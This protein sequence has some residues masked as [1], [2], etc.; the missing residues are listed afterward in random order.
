MPMGPGRSAPF[1][2]RVGDLGR[3]QGVYE[4]SLVAEGGVFSVRGRPVP[5]T[6]SLDLPGDPAFREM[7]SM[8][9][10]YRAAMRRSFEELEP[11]AWE[12]ED[13]F[14]LHPAERC[15][16]CHPSAVATWR[17]MGHSRSWQALVDA[18]RTDD[19]TCVPCHSRLSTPGS[20]A[21]RNPKARRRRR[22]C[23]D[24]HT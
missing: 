18:E 21:G 23:A 22:S 4:V 19:P 8:L 5:L 16:R 15:E 12:G 6:D 10:R 3:F 24:D 17:E 9:A 20:T 7:G 2:V 11:T 14:Q 1:V 13:R